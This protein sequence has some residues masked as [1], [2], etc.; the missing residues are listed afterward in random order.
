VLEVLA[1][2]SGSPRPCL[3][4][5]PIPGRCRYSPAIPRQYWKQRAI[6]EHP[7]TLASLYWIFKIPRDSLP[8]GREQFT[9]RT[10]Y[11]LLNET[12][13]RK[14]D[15]ISQAWPA[16]RAAKPTIRAR[17]I[18]KDGAS[19]LLDPNTITEAGVPTQVTD[20]YSDVKVLTAPLPAVAPGAVVEAEIDY[21]DR[22]TVN[23]G[24]RLDRMS[25]F[26]DVPIQ[27]FKLTLELPAGA[28]AYARLSFLFR[29][30]SAGR[31][32]V[33][34]N[35][36]SEAEKAIRKAMEL[37]PANKQL[38]ADL[39][40][41]L[42]RRNTKLGYVDKDGL[43][44]PI[45]LL[46]GIS[47]DLPDLQL[48]NQ[49]PTDLFYARRFAD[50]QAFYS[51]P[52]GARSRA[53]LRIAS[54]A[55]G[56]NSAAAIREAE[57]LF[58][59]GATRRSVLTGAGQYLIYI[60]EYA[61]A[62]DLLQEAS[63]GSSSGQPDLELLRKARRANEIELSTNGPVAAVQ[64]YALSLLDFRSD[65]VYSDSLTPEWK[66]LTVKDQRDSLV[67]LL[68]PFHRIADVPLKVWSLADLAASAIELLPEGSDS[69]GYRVR[70]ADPTRSGARKTV[71]WVV[72]RGDQYRILGLADAQSAVGGEALALA[73]KGDLAGV[74]RW[75]NWQREEIGVPSSAD[76]L[77]AEPFL[78]LWPPRTG[79]PERE[80]I[81]AAAASLIARGHYYQQGIEVLSAVRA[82]S[83]D[84]VFQ[85]D[86][87]F[88]WAD[89]LSRNLE[90]AEAAPVWRR[91][92]RQHPDSEVAFSALGL[93]LARSGHLD[94]AL[95]LA[96][97][98]KPEEDLYL[99]AQRMRARV[100][101]LQHKYR[102]AVQAYQLACKSS[103]ATAF[104]WN[105]EAWDALFIPESKPDLEAANTANRL[106]RSGNSSTSRR[107]VLCR[108]KSD[109]SRKPAS[110]WFVTCHYHI[111]RSLADPPSI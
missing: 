43:E 84:R 3:C 77:A 98:A 21:E 64:Q 22:E 74:R 54:V 25:L 70:F 75:L 27:F 16:W 19:H 26:G 68:M 44:E 2:S 6:A 53:D 83:Q 107:W 82:G 67:T 81:R 105:N 95:T 8:G 102:E 36:L 108:R 39:A 46:D 52:E 71:A 35:D 100:F 12:G 61:K 97:S 51:R 91:V 30:D 56:D 87:D 106:T 29:H 10:V 86:V 33:V 63:N 49:L 17:V 110:R 28:P 89:G 38:V 58:P 62:A 101:Q 14:L 60:S 50:T 59:D 93:A 15:K 109:N 78:K 47:K 40:V 18:T 11:L 48:A 76:L 7:R 73:Q 69:I 24:G 99:E 96:A 34:G 5:R 37:D 111:P 13:V 94:E 80:Q 32:D 20:L 85:S 92:Q 1:S 90:Y 23:P 65:L 72:K 79:I 45:K 42:E 4:W 55:A 88:A 57:R 41:I 31:L 9:Q 103:K 66:F 104:D